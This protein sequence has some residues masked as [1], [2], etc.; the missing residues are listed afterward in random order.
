MLPRS[1]FHKLSDPLE[2]IQAELHDI[3][4][5]QQETNKQLTKINGTIARH[6][7]EIFGKGSTRGLVP[8]MRVQEES[9]LKVR[10][11]AIVAVSIVSLVGVSNIWLI[12]RSGT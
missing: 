4:T 7:E 12:L 8:R 6:N 2:A 3:K 1:W 10:T 9:W 11:A 5:A